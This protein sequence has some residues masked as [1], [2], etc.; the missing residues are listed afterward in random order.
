[1]DRPADAVFLDLDGVVLD[2][3]PR[4]HRVHEDIMTDLGAAALS[5]PE[6]MRLK[7]ERAS[8]LDLTSLPAPAAKEYQRRWNQL[9]EAP[10]YLAL[11]QY[12]PQAALAVRLL[13][14]RY[15]LVLLCLRRKGAALREQL[16][17]LDFPLVD[18]VLCASPRA[19]ADEVKARMM[20]SSP[21]FSRNSVVVGDT[22][23]D[24]RAGRSLGMTTVAV[25]GG[26]R[27]DALLARESPNV[28]I[29]GIGE[30]PVALK[31]L[32]IGGRP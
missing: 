4:Y 3:W 13:S 5:L 25:R 2:P 32:F 9:I 1:M 16:K 22:E 7:R 30:L 15:H 23:A 27:S 17:A 19:A 6:F 24:I 29:D 26:L 31:A 12:L 11:D 8:L 14:A 28:T 21:Y 20:Q 18:Q 10:A